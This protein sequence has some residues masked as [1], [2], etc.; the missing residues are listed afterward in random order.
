MGEGIA[1]ANTLL[2]E[3]LIS[4]GRASVDSVLVP[5]LAAREIAMR[6]AREP[7][8]A[9]RDPQLIAADEGVNP[10]GRQVVETVLRIEQAENVEVARRKRQRAMVGVFTAM[11][12][13]RT[14]RAPLHRDGGRRR[15]SSRKRM[16]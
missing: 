13:L 7:T 6:L 8:E 2:A 5:G 15:P 1:V 3:V 11:V 12:E 9:L 4:L 14:V 16:A 10:V